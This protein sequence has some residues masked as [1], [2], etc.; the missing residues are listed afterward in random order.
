MWIFPFVN[1]LLDNGWKR[2]HFFS[3]TDYG[4]IRRVI[5]IIYFESFPD[6]E[7]VLENLRA[8]GMDVPL[9]AT[10]FPYIWTGTDL[11]TEFIQLAEGYS[12]WVAP[13]M[14][15]EGDT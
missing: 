15:E 9:N 14:S 13:A 11:W 2:L 6:T 12:W 10:E 3:A 5:F 8:A 7:T 1:R 4:E